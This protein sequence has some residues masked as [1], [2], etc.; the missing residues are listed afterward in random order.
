MLQ[1]EKRLKDAF[2]LFP[3]KIKPVMINMG[4]L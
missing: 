4:T 3:I 1:K 2:K